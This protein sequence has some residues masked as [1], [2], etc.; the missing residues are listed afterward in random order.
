MSDR[1]LTKVSRINGREYKV[2]DTC[3]ILNLQQAIRYLANNVELIDLYTSKDRDNP[4]AQKLV[5]VF[6]RNE[7]KWAY[8]A[9]CKRELKFPDEVD[10]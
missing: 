6:N 8:D 7:S 3:R 2:F 10:D 9:W 4:E 5:F 1:D